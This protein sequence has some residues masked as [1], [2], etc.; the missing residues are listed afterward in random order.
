MLLTVD[1]GNTHTVIGI[2]SGNRLV[3][4]WRIKTDRQGTAHE[5]AATLY[6]LMAM[7]EISFSQIDGFIM[8]C[9]VPQVQ[10]NWLSFANTIVDNPV[11]VNH[12]METGLKVVTENPAEVGADR[13]VN[14][15][16]AFDK[17]ASPLII[18]DFGT[19][20]TLDCVSG[21]AEYLGGAIAPG[22]GISLDALGKQTAKLPRVDIST[23]PQKAIGTTTIEAI[24]AG[25]LFGY[26]GMIDGL[27]VRIQKEFLPEKPKAIATG[28]MAALITPY[29]E[30][31]EA[32]E[33]QLTIR[34]LLLLHE[35][36][37]QTTISS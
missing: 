34:G 15:V 13:I 3:A 11:Q 16:A 35:K 9:V 14:A 6:G 21:Q 30:Y 23:P 37:R 20:I 8:A 17:Y 7:K 29:S 1:I 12:Q 36:S 26:G 18:V 28:G 31:I 27:I 19:A 5:I 10:G 32:V 24:K 22:L 2:F 25:I 4:D 33:P